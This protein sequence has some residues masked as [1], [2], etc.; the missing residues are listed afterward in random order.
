MRISELNGNLVVKFTDYLTGEP[1]YSFLGKHKTTETAKKLI[2]LSVKKG[3]V[4]K[5][6]LIPEISTEGIDGK[7][8]E[9]IEDRNHFDYIFSINKLTAYEGSEYARHRRKIRK[10][11]QNNFEVVKLNLKDPTNQKLLLDLVEWWVRKNKENKESEDY[12]GSEEL[13]NELYAFIRLV[14]S[15]IDLLEGL[16]CVALFVD[17][18]LSGFIVNEKI[19]KDYCLA[20]F[21]KADIKH[22]GIYHFL[23][24]QNA[25]VFLDL[26][27]NYLNQ[28]QDLGLPNLRFSKNIYRPINFLKK[29]SLALKI[30]DKL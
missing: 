6:N 5:L 9:L 19:S 29:Y 16:T 8:L 17:G 22:E 18:V 10:F 30:G 26:G 27:V 2:E 25:K 23:M 1:F 28:E 12:L 14:S 21:G 11:A 3:I 15:P 7:E 20:H 4:P 13:Q 24:Q